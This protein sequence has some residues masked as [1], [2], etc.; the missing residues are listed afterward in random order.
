MGLICMR[1]HGPTFSCLDIFNDPHCS[2]LVA[3]EKK[4][5]SLKS[6]NPSSRSLKSCRSRT[7]G[8]LGGVKQAQC[9]LVPAVCV[10]AGSPRLPTIMYT[11]KVYKETNTNEQYW[12]QSFLLPILIRICNR[13]SLGLKMKYSAVI[14]RDSKAVP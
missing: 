11:H 6:N 2:V 1:R 12:L 9:W 8:D 5:S 3:E 13:G 4:K 7:G 14:K 10:K